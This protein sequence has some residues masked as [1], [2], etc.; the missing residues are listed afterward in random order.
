MLAHWQARTSAIDSLSVSLQSVTS[1]QAT[2]RL[3]DT[4][5]A[6]LEWV[7]HQRQVSVT[8]LVAFGYLILSSHY[9]REVRV[10]LS[11]DSGFALMLDM[12]GDQTLADHLVSMRQPFVVHQGTVDRGTVAN[13]G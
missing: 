1:T 2:A 11:G 10:C 4:L 3:P 5:L 6:Q 12:A 7:A 8:R 13:L 9:R